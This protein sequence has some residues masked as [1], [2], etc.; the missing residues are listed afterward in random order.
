[1]VSTAAL[2]AALRDAYGLAAT[3]VVFLP[4]GYDAAAAVY[5]AAADGRDYFL[6]LRRNGVNPA[7]LALPHFLNE[8]GLAEILAPVPTRMGAL[9][10]PLAGQALIV[11]PF[12]HNAEPLKSGQADDQWRRLGALLRRLHTVDVPPGLLPL[13]SRETF[14]PVASALV[15]RL[16]ARVHHEQFAEPLAAQVAAGWAA[17]AAQIQ[18]LLERAEALSQRLRAA[19]PGR[20]CLCHADPHWS[21]VLV[22]A[23]GQVWLVDWDD[24][25][26]AVKERDLMFVVGGISADWGTPRDTALFFEGYGPAAVDPLALAYYRADWALQDIGEFARQ[27]LETPE[28]SEDERRDAARLFMGLF[29]PGAIVEKALTSAQRR[30]KEPEWNAPSL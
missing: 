15:R 3:E 18:A 22:D 14:V 17:H 20:L 10:H 21:N 4:L 29:E 26:L 30:L 27:V 24:T 25:L 16:N 1:M 23:Q 7:S 5:R 28:A 19:P 9:W 2:A 13:L 8:Q 12:L 6:K 11:Y